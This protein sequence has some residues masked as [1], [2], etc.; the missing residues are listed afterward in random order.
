[1]GGGG[2]GS[3]YRRT[4]IDKSKDPC[5]LCGKE[6]H[7]RS[8]C[9]VMHPQAYGSSVGQAVSNS[10]IRGFGHF[11]M[12]HAV[13]SYDL[14]NVCFQESCY[15]ALDAELLDNFVGD[16]ATDVERFNTEL[17]LGFIRN[18][19]FGIKL[20]VC[21]DGTVVS[22]R[23]RLQK[24]FEAWKSLTDSKMILNII[25]EG[26]KLSFFKVP[27]LASFHNNQSALKHPDFVAEQI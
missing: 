18:S 16:G 19:D 7:W 14:N 24:N 11:E 9:T 23:G 27:E 2:G 25:S 10:K 1:M 6:G 22:P 17:T 5:F 12:F 26:Y 20:Q 3:S 15:N 21:S 4:A 8:D 13:G